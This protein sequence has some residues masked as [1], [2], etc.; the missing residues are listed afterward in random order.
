MAATPLSL[1]VRVA[2]HRVSA[3]QVRSGL[4]YDDSEMGCPE[5]GHE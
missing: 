3:I 2:S 5:T 1:E 4:R